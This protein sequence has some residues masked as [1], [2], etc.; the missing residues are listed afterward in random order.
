MGFLKAI[1][2]VVVVGGLAIGGAAIAS[3]P[4]SSGTI[5]ACYAKSNGGLRVIDAE[6][7]G[8]CVANKEL[9][10]SWNQQGAQGPPG[11]ASLASRE[12]VASS[13]GVDIVSE[14]FEVKQARAQCDA[15]EFVTGGGYELIGSRT[16]T[17]QVTVERN[18]PSGPVLGG[19]PYPTH[20]QVAAMAPVGV[21]SWALLVRAICATPTTDPGPLP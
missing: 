19:P 12:V 20:W 17:S 8:S 10:L 1:A 21:G 16:V 11:P 9:P 7:G 3:I 5:S 4:N 14:G 13:D 15:G 18:V 2:G 6:A